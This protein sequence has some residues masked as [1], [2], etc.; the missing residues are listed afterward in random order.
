LTQKSTGAPPGTLVNT[1][2][3]EVEEVY[4]HLIHY[5][6]ESFYCITELG[7]IP[8][9]NS[10]EN[11][12]WYDVRGLHQI[13]LIK[14]LGKAYGMHPSSMEDVVDVHQRPKMESY[15]GGVLL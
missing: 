5:D 3:R 8:E 7:S 11:V 12:T 13:D 9:D 15:K 2:L 4:V 10:P 14:K 1:G 6:T